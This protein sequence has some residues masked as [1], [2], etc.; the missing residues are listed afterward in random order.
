MKIGRRASVSCSAVAQISGGF[1]KIGRKF[2]SASSGATEKHKYCN[3]THT[4]VVS[5]QAVRSLV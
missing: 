2:V 1:R 4:N 5:S 3:E